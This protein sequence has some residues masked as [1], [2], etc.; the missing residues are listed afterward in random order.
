MRHVAINQGNFIFESL[1]FSRKKETNGVPVGFKSF[2]KTRKLRGKWQ[3]IQSKCIYTEGG[4]GLV[5]INN[6]N[7]NCKS[8]GNIFLKNG[9]S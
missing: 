3:R 4:S 9:Q 7:K 1:F 5:F 2:S 8:S 6:K